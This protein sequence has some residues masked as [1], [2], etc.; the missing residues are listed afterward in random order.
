MRLS[1]RTRL[2]GVAL[3]AAVGL[4]LTACGGGGSDDDTASTDAVITVDG[5]EPQNP[6]VP[7][8]TNETGGGN[9]IDMIFAGLVTYEADGS[10]TLEVAESI[11]SDDNKTWTVTLKDWSFSDGTPV[12]A[13][14]FVDAWNQGAL[15]T[16]AHL[17]SYFYYPIQ[18]FEE[19]QAENPKVD[20]MS[21]L[22]V[23]DDKTFT[24]T[25]NQPESD[26]PARLG[27]SAFYPLPEA[28]FEDLQAYGEN[29]VGNGPY[30]MDGEG[31]WQHDVQIA[32]VPNEDYD[33]ARQA[34]N[35]GLTFKFYTNLDAAYVDVQSGNLDVLKTVPDAYLTTFQDD[36]QV[37]PFSEPGSV[38]QSFT[39]AASMPG[40]GDDEEGHLRR[41][42]ISMAI[43]RAE[44]TEKIF[45][46]TRTPAVDFS[47]PLM[48][49]FTEEIEGNEV[50]EFNPD[51]AKK[52][53]AEADAIKPYNG[54]FQL[55]YNGDGGHEAW[56]EAVTNQISNN[57]GIKAEGKAYPTF[58]ELRTDVTD[59]TID[60]AFRTGW[61]P[62]Y[63]SIFNYLAPL[64]GTGAG[65]NDGDYSNAEFDDLMSQ[66]SA[67]ESDEEREQIYADAQAILMEDL[68]AIPLWYSN[69]AAVAAD[70]VNDVEFNWQNLPE[71]QL[72][73]K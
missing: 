45:A 25:L 48:P 66:A 53:W 24:I 38:F 17:N 10:S 72:L 59:R 1:R 28:A 44:I 20:T 5:S 47:S 31:A 56:V 36:N 40:F 52:L 8:M 39:F 55:A 57:L 42:A 68:P 70:G 30:M 54:T 12:T 71:Y 2:A 15:S 43:D 51:E 4:T 61:Q 26:F 69:I 21:G 37:Q 33:G 50:V 23:V 9:V 22:E 16:N 19:V 65:S 73:T 35:A 63:P 3:L 58:D 14:S 32:L 67:A 34:Q 49:G 64:Y 6:L 46:D 11:E 41:E 13:S 60:I 7:S 18:G 29:P 62:D 27:Y